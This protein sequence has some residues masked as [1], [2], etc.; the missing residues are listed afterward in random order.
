MIWTELIDALP[1]EMTLHPPAPEPALMEAQQ[2]LGRPLPDELAALLRESNGVE[3]E[4][5][6]ELIWPIERIVTDNLVLRSDADLAKLY[7]PFDPL[8]FI[9][10]AGNGDQFALVPHTR[11]PDVFAWDHENDSR[12]WVA[13][14]LAKYLDWWLTGKIKL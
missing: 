6:L 5:W 2:L 8:L 3:A 10:D 12:T 11:R 4:Y 1:G 13:P 9:G 7:M 14:S